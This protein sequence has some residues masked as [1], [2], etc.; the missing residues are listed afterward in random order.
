V[1]ERLGVDAVLVGRVQGGRDP[2]GQAALVPWGS[3][4]AGL[5]GA[6]VAPWPGR[7]PPPAPSEVLRVPRRAE[8]VD[9]TGAPCAVNGRGLLNGEPAQLSIEGGPWQPV[10]AWAGPW[11]VTERWWS[12]RRRR[13]RFQVVTADGAARLLCTERAQWW[14]EAL[15]D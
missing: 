10:A 11:P 12:A 14:V 13:A 3:P 8:V 6:G 1:Q 2:A 9:A 5:S 7:L 4:E 15:Y